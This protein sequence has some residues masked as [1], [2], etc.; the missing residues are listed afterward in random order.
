MASLEQVNAALTVRLNAAIPDT[1]R[2]ADTVPDEAKFASFIK[3]V[4][5]TQNTQEATVEAQAAAQ[6]RLGKQV[7]ALE[8]HELLAEGGSN[9]AVHCKEGEYAKTMCTA[10]TATVCAACP[11]NTWSVG[12]L[13]R[14]CRACTPC[15]IGTTQQSGCTPGGNALCKA[16]P[17]GTFNAEGGEAK[18]GVCN[19]TNVCNAGHLMQSPCHAGTGNA[20]CVPCPAGTFMATSGSATKCTTC[21]ACKN[22][23]PPLQCGGASKGICVDPKMGF[24]P[25]GKSTGCDA[26]RY[27]MRQLK[28]NEF[29]FN[30]QDPDSGNTGAACVLGDN[31]DIGKPG[32]NTYDQARSCGF[33][34]KEM[35]S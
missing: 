29:C 16:C 21:P 35:A 11:G 7:A 23:N 6:V 32:S 28:G 30:P 2:P 27:V 33:T 26:W 3:D 18:C 34:S 14:E 24:A 22:G 8:E 19:M 17:A 12:G 20:L 1:R 4:V 25:A 31:F 10:T 5:D 13:V 9:C 15:M